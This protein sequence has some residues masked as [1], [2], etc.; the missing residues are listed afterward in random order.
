MPLPAALQTKAV[1]AASKVRTMVAPP[2]TTTSI[3]ESSNPNGG[4]PPFDDSSGGDPG[5]TT[6]ESVPATD[7]VNT[8]TSATPSVTVSAA[9]ARPTTPFSERPQ[10]RYAILGLGVVA[11]A[12]AFGALEITKRPRRT[13]AIHIEAVLASSSQEPRA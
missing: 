9:G 8:S 13:S 5:V 11:L 10:S 7:S 3:V 2:T 1:A 12:S 6:Q 4:F